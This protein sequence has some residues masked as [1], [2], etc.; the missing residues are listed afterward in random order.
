MG[1]YDTSR[2]YDEKKRRKEYTALIKKTESQALALRTQL[3]GL[4]VPDRFIGQM[5]DLGNWLALEGKR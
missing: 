5:E 1:H 3:V 4:G 2:E